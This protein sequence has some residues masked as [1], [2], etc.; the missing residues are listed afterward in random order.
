[1][2]HLQHI[3]TA[4]LGV[5]LTLLA[6]SAWAVDG[7]VLI[8]QN[9]ALAGNVTPGDAPGFPVTITQPGSYR[10]SGNLVVPNE[11][12]TGIVVTASA[13]SIDLNGFGIFGPGRPSNDTLFVGVGIT[14][15]N[16]DLNQT[17]IAIRNG[18]IAGMGGSG[19]IITGGGGEIMNVRSHNN[20]GVGIS[21]GEGYLVS[22]NT[23]SFNRFGLWAG[24]AS[25][26]RGNV[27][28]GISRGGEL[29]VPCF[30]REAARGSIVGNVATGGIVG[31]S[32]N[33][34]TRDQNSPAP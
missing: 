22:G 27:V 25:V 33:D 15:S 32:V 31:A 5:L 28:R 12:T 7:V 21:V 30:P 3:P 13:V 16:S 10:L 20:A 4:V 24:S 17:N 6:G 29:L 34:C 8:D 1:M 11:F 9:K 18:T 14:D 2:R 26:V 19:I 23:V